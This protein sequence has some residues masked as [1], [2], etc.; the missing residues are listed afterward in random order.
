MG[1]EVT[2]L[3]STSRS[4]TTRTVLVNYYRKSMP[5]SQIKRKITA[6]FHNSLDLQ[7]CH[8]GEQ[9]LVAYLDTVVD[10]DRVEREIVK[11]LKDFPD[12]PMESSIIT[13]P[14]IYQKHWK[15]ICKSMTRGHVIVFAQGSEC[16]IS[17]PIAKF[18]QRQI[19]E[20]ESEK[21]IRGSKEG[22]IEDINVNI[23]L[24]RKRMNSPSLVFEEMNIG[25]LTE[26]RVIICYIAGLCDPEILKEVKRR[27]KAINI[28]SVLESGYIEELII[29]HPYSCFPQVEQTE[30]PDNMLAQILEGRVAIMVNGSPLAIAVPTVFTQFVQAS[31]DNYENYIYATFLRILRMIAMP[32][33]LYLPALYVAITTIHQEMIPT[34]LVLKIAGAREGVPFPAVL[35]A[36][37]MEFA[38]ELLREAGV[39]LPAQVGQ[40]LSIVGALIIG[41]AAVEAGLVSPIMVVVVAF[42]GISSFVIPAYRLSISFRLLRFVVLLAS[43]FLGLIGF[44]LINLFLLVHLTSMQSFGVPYFEP[45]GPMK[46]GQMKDWFFRQW[47]GQKAKQPYNIAL[48]RMDDQMIFEQDT[49]TRKGNYRK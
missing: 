16:P 17:I 24:L 18:S 4:I 30:K 8:I 36:L 19:T 14:I 2:D 25:T 46:Y 33:A 38:F 39:R 27:L 29:D 26:T 32:I 34:D 41:Q 23:S 21:Q 43:S 6:M 47:W 28:Q 45:L 11:Q 20:P 12:Q 10:L 15:K 48:S 3:S 5:L 44:V 1:K 35:E 42:S 13:T 49:K 40:A 31:E 22:F 7:L 37:I 9:F